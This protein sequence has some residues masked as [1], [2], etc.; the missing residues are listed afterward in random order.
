MTTKTNTFA[1]SAG[2]YYFDRIGTL[3]GPLTKCNP[4]DVFDFE[5]EEHDWRKY[6]SYTGRGPHQRDLIESLETRIFR[7]LAHATVPGLID[8]D[9][10]LPYPLV[11]ALSDENSSIDTGYDRLRFIAAELA[12]DIFLPEQMLGD[13]PL[14]D[15]SEETDGGPTD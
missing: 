8:A 1:L 5:T 3:H 14:P 9:T 6:G 10:G 4:Y 2:N 13:F 15:E 7:I 11:D 12:R